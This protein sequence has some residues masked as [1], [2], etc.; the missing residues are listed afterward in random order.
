MSRTSAVVADEVGRRARDLDRY[1]KKIDRL[2]MERAL[3]DR[4]AE[5]AYTG[6]FLEFHA[7]LERALENLFLGLLRGR[8]QS[9]DRSVRPLITILSDRVARDIVAS[10]RPYVDW[11][12]Y[13]RH[14]MPRANAFFC[15]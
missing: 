12:P 6:G 13:P 9:S 14:T 10:G 1:L 3:G 4:D 8:L 5:R 15:W 2:H 7:Y 11:L